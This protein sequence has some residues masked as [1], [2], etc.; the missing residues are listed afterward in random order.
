[1]AVGSQCFSRQNTYMADV[2]VCA[3][4]SAY[5]GGGAWHALHYAPMTIVPVVGGLRISGRAVV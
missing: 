5:L 2:H 3:L 4:I 1:M